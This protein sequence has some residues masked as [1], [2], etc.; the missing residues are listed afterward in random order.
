MRQKSTV[1]IRAGSFKELKVQ[2]DSLKKTAGEQEMADLNTALD[3]LSEVCKRMIDQKASVDME[4]VSDITKMVASLQ[5]SIGELEQMGYRNLASPGE[6][7]QP[8][9]IPSQPGVPEAA[10]QGLEPSGGVPG[11]G[12]AL[13]MRGT[14]PAANAGAP[15]A[16]SSS[17][18]LVSQRS[19]GVGPDCAIAS[20]SHS[21]RSAAGSVVGST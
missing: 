8:G 11:V 14:S 1:Q 13:W 18:G 7:P 21:A 4:Y 15:V 5:E 2:S 16:P 10:G 6:E 3:L 9:Q 20:L 19:A 12:T 17:N